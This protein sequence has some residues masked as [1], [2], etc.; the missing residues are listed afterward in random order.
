MSSQKILLK[1][2]WAKMWFKEQ[3]G[4]RMLF[5]FIYL[6]S[7][8]CRKFGLEIPISYISRTLLGQYEIR[9]LLLNFFFFCIY[10]M[11]QDAEIFLFP[12]DLAHLLN[13]CVA[14]LLS[15]P[16]GWWWGIF[17]YLCKLWI[18]VFLNT[19]WWKQ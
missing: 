8:I 9:L 10:I 6:L 2:S 19:G 13:Y 12:S 4:K 1:W 17:P 3:K 14:I 16:G 11:F 15:I 7:I 5:E 18:S